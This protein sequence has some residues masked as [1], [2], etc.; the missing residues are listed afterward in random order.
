MFFTLNTSIALHS[1]IIP[2]PLA[3][4]EY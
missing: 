4:Y 3:R 2:G 1:N